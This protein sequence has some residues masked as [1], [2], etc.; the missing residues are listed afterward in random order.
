MD[1]K[2]C[3]KRLV[4]RFF[5]GEICAGTPENHKGFCKVENKQKRKKLAFNKILMI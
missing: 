4:H 2:D 1:I 3:S 5:G